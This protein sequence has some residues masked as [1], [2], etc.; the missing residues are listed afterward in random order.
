MVAR[1]SKK[2]SHESVAEEAD[3]LRARVVPLAA[4]D[5]MAYRDVLEARASVAGSGSAASRK[6]VNDALSAAA[7]VPLAIAEMGAEVGDLAAELAI[8]GKPEL[9][10]DAL[11]GV[12]LAEACVRAAAELVL[13]NLAH[14]P[15]DERCRAARRASARA[16]GAVRRAGAVAAGTGS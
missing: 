2:R 7:R 3:A 16:A 4:K 1:A 15:V 6:L 10:G 12:W 14:T 9:R 8:G 5:A 13:I 11:T